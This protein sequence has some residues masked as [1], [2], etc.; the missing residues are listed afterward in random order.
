MENFEKKYSV[1]INITQTLSKEIQCRR[2]VYTE[3]LTEGCTDSQK[4][5][6]FP[7]TPFCLLIIERCV[8]A[9]ACVCVRAHVRAHVCLHICACTHAHVDTTF[10]HLLIF[11]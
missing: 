3:R 4:Y 11:L 2:L 10:C 9:S 7:T 1:A 5:M 6:V 8:V